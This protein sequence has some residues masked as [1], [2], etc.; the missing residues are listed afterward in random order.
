MALDVED[1][2]RRFGPMVMRRCRRL[3]RDEE[4]ALDATQ[5]VFV[6]LIRH[7]AKLEGTATSSLLFRIATNVCLNRIRSR[8][9]KPETP[10]DELLSAIADADEGDGGFARALLQR[11]FKDELDSTRT[12]AV[13]HLVDGMTLEE[14]AA[15][16]GMSV[17]GVRK[18]LRGLKA[19]VAALEEVA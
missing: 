5:D 10:D 19:R 9:R 15:E 16:V 4:L 7:E 2:Y 17:S 8:R 1:C 3:L 12:I 11:V 13:L 14:V 6:Q 18:R